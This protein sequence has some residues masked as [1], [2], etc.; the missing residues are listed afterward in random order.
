MYGDEG[1]G[2]VL[3]AYLIREGLKYASSLEHNFPT[4][5]ADIDRVLQFQRQLKSCIA[6]SIKNYLN[7]RNQKNNCFQQTL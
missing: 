3:T 1:K 2:Q 5:D 7:W 4:H 6:D